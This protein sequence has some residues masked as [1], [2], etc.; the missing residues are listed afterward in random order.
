MD[1]GS[2]ADYEDPEAYDIMV[3]LQELIA[4]E[5]PITQ[6]DIDIL[7]K[8]ENQLREVQAERIRTQDPL[9]QALEQGDIFDDTVL[10]E[11]EMADLSFQG[12]NPNWFSFQR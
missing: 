12:T 2:R 11:T 4:E 1:L 7:D 8:Y 3:E 9:Y 10:P 6:R 5:K